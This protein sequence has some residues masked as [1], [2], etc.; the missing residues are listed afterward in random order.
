MLLEKNFVF[1]LPEFSRTLFSLVTILME[2]APLH[3]VESTRMWP[4]LR[5]GQAL[6]QL[7]RVTGVVRSYHGVTEGLWLLALA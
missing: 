5:G 2:V 3:L 1:R 7:C 6:K 4:N